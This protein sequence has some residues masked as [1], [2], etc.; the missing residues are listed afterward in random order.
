MNIPSFLLLLDFECSMQRISHKV[1]SNEVDGDTITLGSRQTVKDCKTQ[2]VHKSDCRGVQYDVDQQG[3]HVC[4]LITGPL[5]I[6]D[7]KCCDLY[8]K[9]CPGETSLKSRWK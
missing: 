3:D 9:T 1:V 5:L 2:C 4:F 7:D 6:Q 8:I